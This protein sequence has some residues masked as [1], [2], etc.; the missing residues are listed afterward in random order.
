[1]LRTLASKVLPL[2]D[3]IVVLPGHGEQT[4]IGQERS[5]NPFLRDVA[6]RDLADPENA[7]ALLPPARGL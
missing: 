4:S 1:M 6:G 5:S 7:P 3:N 2:P